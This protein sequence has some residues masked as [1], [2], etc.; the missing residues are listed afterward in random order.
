MDMLATSLVLSAA[1]VGTLY[2]ALI[3]AQGGSPSLFVGAGVLAILSVILATLASVRGARKAVTV[4]S[5]DRESRAALSLTLLVNAL[6]VVALVVGFLYAF[7]GL[8]I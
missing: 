8:R 6:I 4:P 2:F 3:G 1:A 7:T 5:E